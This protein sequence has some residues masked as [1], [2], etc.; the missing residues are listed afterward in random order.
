MSQAKQGNGRWIGTAFLVG[1]LSASG[2]L[3]AED[4]V[5]AENGGHIIGRNSEDLRDACR[6]VVAISG[7]FKRTGLDA[8]LNTE[9][10]LV[11]D[12]NEKI[13][14]G[15]E[16]GRFDGT[17]RQI[18]ILDFDSIV[19]R[20]KHAEPGLGRITTRDHWRS[21]IAHELAHAAVHA[22]CEMT[23]PSRAIH[24]YVAAVA[25]IDSLP[26]SIRTALLRNYPDVD[27]FAQESEI[28]EIYYALNPHYF[29]VKSYKHFRQLAD[30]PAFFR[31]A[32]HQ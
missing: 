20:S 30:A 6:A 18:L 16:F 15:N 12:A 17:K 22:G 31:R 14:D 27:A 29:A 21:F 8:A 28:T 19:V 5:C 25:Q 13:L 7:F 4:F 11:D 24:E 10:R 23:C 3:R 9:I 26:E 2:T 1:V 32:L